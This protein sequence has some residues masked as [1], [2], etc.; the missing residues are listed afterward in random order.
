MKGGLEVII[1]SDGF[2]MTCDRGGITEEVRH[3]ELDLGGELASFCERHSLKTRTVNLF[4]AEALV[5]MAAIDLPSSTPNIGEVVRFQLGVL[6]PFPGDNILSSYSAVRD[7]A[8]FRVTITAAGSGQVVAGVE[9]LLRAGFVVRGLYPES[10]RY[11]TGKWRRLRWALVMPGT[12]SKIF[13]FAGGACVE[14]F[15][16]NNGDFAY[17]E[18]VEACATENIFHLDP[19]TG[20]R[21]KSARMLLA[22]PPLLKDY[23]MLPASYRRRDN[24][25][26]A[27]IVLLFFNLVTLAAFG[28]L[29]FIDQT[30]RISQADQEIGRLQPLVGKVKRTKDQIRQTEQFLASVAR[31]KGNPDLF[32]F[33]ASLT[34][35]LPEGSYLNQL[36]FTAGKDS[37]VINGFTDNI[38][39][40]TEKLQA[41]G[42]SRLQSTSRRQNMTYFQVEISLP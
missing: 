22:T 19:P 42:E 33:L 6:A 35:A 14:R 34:L 25:K 10:Q 30:K 13:V 41:V 36:Q 5:Y 37:V 18:L 4:L 15:L 8:N 2:T 23:N 17:D 1:R 40:L 31:M 26:I 38:G 3:D 7:G 24:L 32:A 27:I 11:V 28:A 20:S 39:D 21:F 12:L 9:A 29:T 16:I